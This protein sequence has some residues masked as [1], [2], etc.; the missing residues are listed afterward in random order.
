M[1]TPMLVELQAAKNQTTGRSIRK[2]RQVTVF[3]ENLP[4]R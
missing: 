1:R 4:K 3:L 2:I